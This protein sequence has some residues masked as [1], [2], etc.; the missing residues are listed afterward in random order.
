MQQ[1]DKRYVVGEIWNR[2]VCSRHCYLQ[3]TRNSRG[4]G[5]K[6]GSFPY[7]YSGT[8]YFTFIIDYREI[9]VIYATHSAAVTDATYTRDANK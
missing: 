5:L 4:I 7:V 1:R 6:A 2:V 8:F 3:N 9:T